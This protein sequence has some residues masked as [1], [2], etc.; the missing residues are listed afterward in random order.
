[1]INFYARSFRKQTPR[2]PHKNYNTLR[3]GCQ[4]NNQFNFILGIYFCNFVHHTEFNVYMRLINNYCCKFKRPVGKTVLIHK[5]QYWQ[6]LDS[7]L[8]SVH[9]N[10]PLLLLCWS[11]CND[12]SLYRAMLLFLNTW[13]N[14]NWSPAICYKRSANRPK[15]SLLSSP[16]NQV[17]FDPVWKAD[18][19]TWH[20]IFS[21]E[22]M[23]PFNNV[24]LI[25]QKSSKH[26]HNHLIWKNGC[27]LCDVITCKAGIHYSSTDL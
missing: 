18:Y 5:R 23:Q 20:D 24:K 11:S 9:K 27:S 3:H 1:M 16:I 14:W 12:T 8:F 7:R 13:T 22:Q 6:F 25:S 15:N 4:L 21:S 17:T 26:L 2:K 10:E 19:N